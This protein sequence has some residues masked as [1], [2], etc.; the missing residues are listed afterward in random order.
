MELTDV[1]THSTF[2][3]DGVSSLQDMVARAAEL[4]LRYYGISDH[5]DYD[6]RALHLTVNGKEI[7]YLDEAAYFAA[8]R[9][10]QEAYKG[11]PLCVLV[12]AEFGFAPL[13]RCIE[14]YAEIIEKRRP[15]FIMNSVHTVGDT[16]CWFLHYFEG[17]SKEYAYRL[18]LERVRQS[19]EAPYAYDVVAH[20]GYVARNAPYP[21]PKLRYE[22]FSRDLDDIL[23]TVVAKG[24]IL[25]VNTSPRRA[26]S[27]FLPDTD[28]LTRYFELGGRAVSYASD[29]HDTKRICDKREEAVAAL[30]QIGFEFLS[31]PAN[32]KIIQVTL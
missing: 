32:G 1:H 3:A 17:K 31:V 28:I 14:E 16:D 18:Y 11:T 15:D 23:K 19:L 21:D 13:A 2:S 26:G 27:A 10:L 24:K 5:F 8:A 30:K 29:A 4:G 12:G 25:E 9:A 22:E 20:L 6:Y 7:P